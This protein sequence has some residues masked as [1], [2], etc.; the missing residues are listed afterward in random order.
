MA[1]DSEK[2]KIRLVE[3]DLAQ[4]NEFVKGVLATGAGL[5]GSAIT[6]WLALLGFAF[7][8]KL[9]SLAVLAAVVPLAFWIADGY[10][11]W[12]YGEASAHAHRI[13]RL[14]ASYYDMLSRRK[15]DPDTELRFRAKLRAH[16]YGLFIGFQSNFGLRQ[17][18]RARPRIFYRVL[19][20][21]LVLVAIGLVVFIHLTLVP[22]QPCGAARP[23]Q[24]SLPAASTYTGLPRAKPTST[25]SSKIRPP[26]TRGPDRWAV[27]EGGGR[28]PVPRGEWPVLLPELRTVSSELAAAVRYQPV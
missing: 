25:V 4:T 21:F 11:G 1:D 20:P 26:I 12:L 9:S 3:A 7:Q 14:L 13:E 6:I 16:R 2:E 8:Q 22:T 23:G 5:R 24:A 27:R 18:W 15:D 10:H 28:W 17:L 19:Y